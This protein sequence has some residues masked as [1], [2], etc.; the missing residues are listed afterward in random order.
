[1]PSNLPIQPTDISFRFSGGTNNQ[2]P[3]NSIGGAMSAYSPSTYTM[4]NLFPSVNMSGSHAQVI[5]ARC[6]YVVNTNLLYTLKDVS[7]FV[8]NNA[9]SNVVM[10]MNL[11]PTVQRLVMYP[12]N[13][14]GEISFKYEHNGCVATVPSGTSQQEFAINLQEKLAEI[15]ELENVTVSI[16]MANT[17]D[18]NFNDYR[19]SPIQVL[20][21][22]MLPEGEVTAEMFMLNAGSPVNATAPGSNITYFSATDVV[23]LPDL[24]PG[25]FIPIWLKRTIPKG[26]LAS[27]K[28]SF[29]LKVLGRP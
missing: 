16:P 19:Y 26:T 22:T 11:R 13:F 27:S 1:M 21:N 7:L 29:K 5:D 9:N 12:F 6:L 8:E 10:G 17:Y 2:S 24:L 3:T 4:E 14:G 20:E 25:D 23:Q 28:T 15:P 18:I